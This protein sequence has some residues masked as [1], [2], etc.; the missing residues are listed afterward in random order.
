MSG[1]LNI[2]LFNSLSYWPRVPATRYRLISITWRAIEG[3]EVD[4]RMEKLMGSLWEG[5]V[6][7]K[8][9]NMIEK[10]DEFL[11]QREH[12]VHWKRSVVGRTRGYRSVSLSQ[13]H[14]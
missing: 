9:R 10:E 1:L 8:G 13:K 11:W 5:R 3:G 14:K 4:G 6:D 2:N 12:R 7:G